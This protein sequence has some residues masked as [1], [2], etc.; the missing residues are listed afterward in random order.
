MIQVPARKN[1]VKNHA[2][3]N[4]LR[5]VNGFEIQAVQNHHH[6]IKRVSKRRH[7]CV[8]RGT[9]SILGRFSSNL[10]SP[11]E[12]DIVPTWTKGLI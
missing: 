10:W 9:G 2:K 6:V 12:M 7:A 1:S 11:K 3:R 4:V 8:V 5:N